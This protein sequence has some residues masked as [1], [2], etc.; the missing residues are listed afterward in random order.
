MAIESKRLLGENSLPLPSR[1]EFEDTDSDLSFRQVE[2][3][4]YRRLLVQNA[5][6]VLSTWVLF[7]MFVFGLTCGLVTARLYLWPPMPHSLTFCI[8]SL[9]CEQYSQLTLSAP[10]DT[11]I[12]YMRP[13]RHETAYKSPYIGPPNPEQEQAW[14]SLVA[15]K[16]LWF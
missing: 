2:K 7:I 4:P 16:S 14:E 11:A 15:R 6:N 3:K 12:T 13:A 5:R 9:S 1:D 8:P 10:A